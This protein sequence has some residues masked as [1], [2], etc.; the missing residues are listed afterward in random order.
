MVRSETDGSC[1][2]NSK[3][4]L[5]EYKLQQDTLIIWHDESGLDLA[6]SFQDQSGCLDIWG[7]IEEVQKR[8]AA[9]SHDID[10]I[11]GFHN[12]QDEDANT[13]FQLQSDFKLPEPTIKNLEELEK[14]FCI[15]VKS[16]PTREHLLKIVMEMDFFETFIE[17][18]EQ[19]E[20]LDMLTE[21]YQLS[22]IVKCLCKS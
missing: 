13:T 21:C 18:L 12:T 22:T 1:V 11:A 7:Q 20:D 17:L 19:C 2:L 16:M 14:I 5:T 6:L 15:A 9:D 8:L 4:L 10:N 3:I